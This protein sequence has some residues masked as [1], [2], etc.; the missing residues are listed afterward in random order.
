MAHSKK[1]Q[2]RKSKPQLLYILLILNKK[3]CLTIG[4]C[5]SYLNLEIME[6]KKKKIF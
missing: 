4:R 3:N 6:F 2:N 5:N 1:N